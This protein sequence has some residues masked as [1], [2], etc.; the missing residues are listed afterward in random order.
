MERSSSITGYRKRPET[1]VEKQPYKKEN[2]KRA[3]YYIYSNYL[4]QI[5]RRIEGRRPAFG[6]CRR[7]DI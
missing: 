1:V 2:G 4:V 6:R 5:I 3:P 7:L